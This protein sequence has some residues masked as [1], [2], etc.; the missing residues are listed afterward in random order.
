MKY[1]YIY[2]YKEERNGLFRSAKKEEKN[3]QQAVRE[4]S[5]IRDYDFLSTSFYLS[6]LIS[7]PTRFIIHFKHKLHEPLLPL[8]ERFSVFDRL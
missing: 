6:L 8:R 7:V 3:E 1:I 5:T 4:N 2:I